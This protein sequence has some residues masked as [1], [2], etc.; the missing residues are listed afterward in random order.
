M[1]VGDVGI[2][3][4]VDLCCPPTGAEMCFIIRAAACGDR[5]NER[6]RIAGLRWAE[7]AARTVLRTA[8]FTRVS[9]SR[10]RSDF[11][12]RAAAATERKESETF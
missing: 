12:K 1:R 4:I 7:A 2:R 3:W 5:V 8:I 10:G 9:Q 11:G 6:M